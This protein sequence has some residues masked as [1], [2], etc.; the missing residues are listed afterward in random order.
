MNEYDKPGQ[1]RVK[2][3]M[4]RTD[5]GDLPDGINATPRESE[6]GMHYL[7]EEDHVLMMTEDYERIRDSPRTQGET[8]DLDAIVSKRTLPGSDE[9]EPPDAHLRSLNIELLRPNNG[10]GVPETVTELRRPWSLLEDDGHVAQFVPR[11][12]PNHILPLSWHGGWHAV[13]DPTPAA[14]LR[15]P[16][17][18]RLLAQP[19]TGVVV[20]M[21][22]TGLAADLRSWF[23]DRIE[24]PFD[25]DPIGDATGH[26][27][28]AD[29]HGTMTAGI[30]AARAP[31]AKL[32]VRAVKAMPGG[33]D[34]YISDKN[35]AAA[36][37]ALADDGADII[38]LSVGGQSH[39][40]TGMGATIAAI[41][42]L[43]RTHPE[44]VVVAAAGNSHSGVPQYPAAM[45][46]VIG[47]GAVKNSTDDRAAFSNF[48]NWVNA[49]APGVDVHST[50]VHW[51]KPNQ[52]VFNGFATWSG[53]SFSTP[54]VAAAIANRRSPGGW[55]QLL[56]FLRPRSAREAADRLIHDPSLPRKSGL[57]V[58]VR[59]KSYVS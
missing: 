58:I 9:L 24:G 49:S 52:T 14:A 56:W 27:S 8:R 17:R 29:A 1:D 2:P 36:I 23:D 31:G 13:D 22:D 51:N 39:G 44:V 50:F 34:H 16:P 10:A 33:Y 54:M 5:V 41:E 47:V 11:V 59:P 21:V 20:A 42:E 19:G 35:L 6:D 32:I 26:R 7:Y 53:T 48:G 25:L 40:H 38:S 4:H 15:R 3:G 37:T 43:Q 12:W 30:V 28:E 55:R 45:D 57:G 18:R 46:G